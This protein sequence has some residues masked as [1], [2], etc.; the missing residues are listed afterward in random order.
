MYKIIGADQKE[1]G[2]VT[3]DQLRQW[4]A[5]GR[6]N[7]Q[8]RVRA[9]GSE[10][11]Q[12]LSAFPE[13]AGIPGAAAAATPPPLSG[14]TVAVPIEN[15][16]A[17]DYTLDI[18][19]CLSRGWALV[20]KDFWPIVGVSFLVMVVSGVLNQ[21]IGLFT[22]PA[23]N[24]M[25]VEHRVL[26]GEIFVILLATL[27]SAPIYTV[28]M[29]GLFKYFLKLIRGAPASVGDAFSGFGPD[30]GQLVLLGLVQ[31][32]LVDIGFA[33]CFLPGIYLAVCWYFAVPLVI[34]R[35]LGFWAA[36]ELSRKM[37]SKHWFIALGLMLVVGL[38]AVSGIIACCIG[39]FA[40]LPIG[41]AALMYAYEDIFGRRS[42]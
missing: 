22:R 24:E 18:G 39:I 4:I 30:L 16:L 1:Y 11:W 3:G 28:L 26:P 42:G 23:I 17:R 19:N 2:P 32:L 20:K 34:D 31:S 14:E 36:M 33:F 5:E 6:M 12:P 25:V 35:R 8:T 29:A 10:T 40:T 41:F 38:V 13:F 9:E 15:I 21:I 27:L 37:V 7:A